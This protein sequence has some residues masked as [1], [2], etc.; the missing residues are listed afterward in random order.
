V[1][2]LLGVYVGDQIHKRWLP[3]AIAQMK[4]S[5]R[6]LTNDIENLIRVCMCRT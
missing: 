5:P 1:N 2:E 4:F 3:D 6:K